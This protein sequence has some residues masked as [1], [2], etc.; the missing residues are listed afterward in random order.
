MVYG[1]DGGV[2]RGANDPKDKYYVTKPKTT[3]DNT[4]TDEILE[5]EP[6]KLN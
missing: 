1:I 2:Q 4:D 5:I 6:K 3:R